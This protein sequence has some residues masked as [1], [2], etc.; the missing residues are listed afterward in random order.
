MTHQ[1]FKSLEWGRQQ[2][3][4]TLTV[5]LHGFNLFQLPSPRWVVQHLH[6]SYAHHCSRLSTRQYPPRCGLA[7]PKNGVQ[8]SRSLEA[9]HVHGEDKRRV[10]GFIHCGSINVLLDTLRPS[11]VL[12][13]SPLGKELNALARRLS[14]QFKRV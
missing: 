10:S 9:H 7:L 1:E 12:A 6:P 11:L 13:G 5:F 4:D 14:R 3:V 8:D 2:F